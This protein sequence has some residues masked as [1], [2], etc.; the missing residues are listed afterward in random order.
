MISQGQQ[1]TN[2]K[3]TVED[4][5]LFEQNQIA[6]SAYI[7][8]FKYH[9]LGYI[10]KENVGLCKIGIPYSI[11]G[12]KANIPTWLLVFLKGLPCESSVFYYFDLHGSNQI[13]KVISKFPEMKSFEKIC[14]RANADTDWN[15]FISN[16][17]NFARNGT[18]IK[19]LNANHLLNRSN[20]YKKISGLILRGVELGFYGSFNL[21]WYQSE[22]RLIEKLARLNL[23]DFWITHNFDITSL[24]YQK[25][26]MAKEL[27]NHICRRV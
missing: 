7:E 10:V 5:I 2:S 3:K 24:E 6:D 12:V 16:V 15:S 20:A 25:E 26:K 22:S 9:Y 21:K 4:I 23:V 11:Q 17:W 8:W 13:S 1:F 14:F 19:L 18:E 27:Y